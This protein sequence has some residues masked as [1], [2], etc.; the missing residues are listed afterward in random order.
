MQAAAAESAGN[1]AALR[2]VC[3]AV[4]LASDA[5]LSLNVYG[6]TATTEPVAAPWLTLWQAWLQ[7]HDAALDESDPDDESAECASARWPVLLG[8]AFRLALRLDCRVGEQPVCG[9]P[10]LGAMRPIETHP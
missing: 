1:R 8:R 10:G 3:A 9:W 2:D 5:M 6:L 4:R 7:W